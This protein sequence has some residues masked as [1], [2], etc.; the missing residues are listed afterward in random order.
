V[1]VPVTRRPAICLNMIV[2]NEARMRNDAHIIQKTLDAVAPYI[3]SWIVVDTG[4]DDG[5]QYLIT[6]HMARLGIPGKLYERPWRNFGHNRTEAL[7]LA[8]GHGDYI[9]VIDADDVLVGTPD[10][11]QVSADAYRLRYRQG[12]TIGWR[13]QLFRDGLRWRYEGVVYETPSCDDPYVAVRL[14]GEYHIEYR[15][16]GTPSQDPGN[17][18]RDT[19]LLLAEVER[20]SE[21]LRAVVLLAKNYFEAGDFVNARKWYARRLEMGILSST[22]EVFIA[23]HRLAESMQQLGE[24]WSDVQDAYLKAWAFR[25]TR[26]EPLFAIAFHYRVENDFLLGY[27]FAQR[28]AEIPLPPDDLAVRADVY[29]WRAI[30][31]QAVCASWIGKH[32]E[33]F[34]LWRSVLA[35]PDLPDRDRGRIAVN[36]DICVPAMIEAALSYPSELVGALVA[37]PRDAEVTVSLIAGPDHAATEQTL[38]SFLNCCT[39]LSRVGRFLVVYVGMSALDRARLRE[40]AMLR[41]QYGFVEFVDCGDAVG[42]AGLLAQLRKQIGGRFWLHLGHGWRFFA[43]EDFIT[44]LTA[45]LE[46]EAQVF[47]VGINFGDAVELSGACAA[48]EAVRRTP[49][50]GRYV[51]ADAVASGPAMFDTARLDQAGGLDGTDP[52]PLAALEQRATTAG[53]RTATLDEVLCEG[54]TAQAATTVAEYSSPTIPPPPAIHRFCIAHIEP[55]IPESWYDHCIALGSYRPDS[56]SHVS[57]LDQF[58]HEARPVAYGAAGSHVLPIAIERFASTA[59]LIEISWHRKRVLPSPVGVQSPVLP[60]M[61]ELTVEDAKKIPELSLFTP[62]NDSGFLLI[63]PQYFPN[64]IIGHYAYHHDL[65]DLLDY[66]SLAIE[67]DVLDRESAAELLTMKLLIPGGAEYGIFPKSFLIPTLSQIERVGREFLHRYSNRLKT[68]NKYQIRAVHF[69]SERLGSFMVIRHLSE[70]YSNNI[71]ADIFGYLTCIVESGSH[72]RYGV[73]D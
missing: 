35:R 72:Y 2:R 57:H 50:A 33:A 29:A 67:M 3:S 26:A 17:D 21:D 66:T 59:E 30:D 71:P 62:P 25:P 56:A 64:S 38:N 1:S 53:L 36:R 13:T 70:K 49:D 47:Q 12:D 65:R 8:R 58:W 34:A 22:E 73:A 19:A 20:N 14:E 32:P 6:N 16:F 60:E 55:L 37:G 24:P 54:S 11:A 23:M 18:A 51:L 61:N 52:D 28:A 4:S 42:A 68:Y 44:R 10:F 48:E 40:R 5:T 9:W 27:Q 41:E 43:P 45:V 46:A 69:L 31:E 39:D 7:D 63:Q 15:P